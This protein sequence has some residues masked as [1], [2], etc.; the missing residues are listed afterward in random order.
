MEH[1]RIVEALNR[2][3]K[4]LGVLPELA[5]LRPQFAITIFE[6]LA[7]TNQTAWDLVDQGASAGTVVIAQQQSAGRGQW[8]HTWMSAAGGLY[9]SLV[10]EPTLTIADANWL[11]LA[12]AWGIATSLA[13]LGI[14]I[15]LKWPNDLVSQGRK[16][17]GILTETRLAA[18]DTSSTEAARAIQTVVIGI[19]INWLN[20]LPPKAVSLKQLLPDSPLEGLKGLEDLAAIALRGL[21]Q[22]YQY[23]QY[24]GTPAMTLAYHRKLSNMG[25]IITVDG[26][27][28]KVL[29]VSSKG[30]LSVSLSHK[31]RK[32]TRSF[33]PG[34]ITLG[35]NS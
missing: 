2:P 27:L 31:E 3:A 4:A 5:N 1:W 35:Y 6:T 20:P 13:N 29:G 30:N 7:S 34:E 14:P 9:L 22:G 24:K 8:G 10:L 17:G 23:W 28:G 16:V 15:E 25:Q 12:S 32:F 26:H 18:S 33:Q 19:G 11:T 21:L